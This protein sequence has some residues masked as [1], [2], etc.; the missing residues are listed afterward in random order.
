MESV[1]VN[2]YFENS[3]CEE[4]ISGGDVGSRKGC[5]GLGFS[6]C[7]LGR[8]PQITIKRCWEACGKELEIQAGKVTVGARAWESEDAGS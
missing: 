5:S 8:R 2:N 4:E 3:G 7:I 6:S 1:G